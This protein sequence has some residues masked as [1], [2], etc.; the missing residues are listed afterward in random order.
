[1][2]TDRPKALDA[3]DQRLLTAERKGWDAAQAGQPLT[4]CPYRDVR[5]RS[6]YVTFSRAYMKAWLKGW[7][8]FKD[9]GKRP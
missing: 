7:R 2:K 9:D 1:M 4:D 5:T 8:R 3:S 6:G